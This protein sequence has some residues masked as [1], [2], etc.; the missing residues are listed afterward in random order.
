MTIS[1]KSAFI[2]LSVEPV[3]PV[4][5][6]KKAMAIRREAYKGA[7]G[8][9]MVDAKIVQSGGDSVRGQIL[10]ADG[11]YNYINTLQFKPKLSSE[12]CPKLDSGAQIPQILSQ[13]PTKDKLVRQNAALRQMPLK[14][15][16]EA[17]VRGGTIIYYKTSLH[18]VPLDLPTLNSIEASMCRVHH[19]TEHILRGFAITKSY[20]TGALFFD[21]AKA[22]DKS[23]IRSSL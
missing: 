12:L 14:P 4:G 8:L 2:Y 9:T 22:F 21:I 10:G 20:T 1:E 23:G 17:S 11:I 15:Q 7:N 19:I 5:T 13:I 18:C 3:W 16:D 6:P